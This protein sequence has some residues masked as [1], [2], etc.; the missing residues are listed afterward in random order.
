MCMTL[1]FAADRPRPRPW[2][3]LSVE[4]SHREWLRL[5]AALPRPL[6]VCRGCDMPYGRKDAHELFEGLC[7]CCGGRAL[8]EMTY[9]FIFAV[10]RKAKK[11]AARRLRRLA[12]M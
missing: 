10:S 11:R 6:P 1:E 7:N 4:E 2:S 3:D 12:E 5:N 9:D 8:E